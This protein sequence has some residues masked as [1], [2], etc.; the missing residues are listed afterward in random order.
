MGIGGH[1][2]G[3]KKLRHLR[4]V[5]GLSIDRAYRRNRLCEARVIED[6]FCTHYSIDPLTEQYVKIEHP[7]HWAS[8][9]KEAR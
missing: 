3:E 8:C 2:L 4:Q 5:T 7:I 9:P 6:D 1:M